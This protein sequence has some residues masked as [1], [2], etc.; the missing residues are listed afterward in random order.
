ML[1]CHVLRNPGLWFAET[2]ADVECARTFCA[3]CLI[4]RQC[5]TA[6]LERAERWGF[7]PGRDR[8]SQTFA[9]GRHC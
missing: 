9:Q 7:R 1:L 4:R 5:L 8:E 2:L 6:A 3:N